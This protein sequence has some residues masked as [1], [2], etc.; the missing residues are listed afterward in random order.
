MTYT[1]IGTIDSSGG[2]IYRSNR[3]FASTNLLLLDNPVIKLDFTGAAAS[4][5]IITFTDSLSE[6]VAEWTIDD[7]LKVNY[8]EIGDVLRYA[9]QPVTLTADQFTD[10]G[11]AL[12]M[13]I[14]AYDSSDVALQTT[15][16]SYTAYRSS[17][18]TNIIASTGNNYVYWSLPSRFRMLFAS[19][20][21]NHAAYNIIAAYP[22]TGRLRYQ[23]YNGSS[24]MTNGSRVVTR[25]EA[26]NWL[27]SSQ[28]T[29]VVAIG[30]DTT[31][32][33]VEQPSCE[34]TLIALKW[35]SRIGGC[36][37][38]I[39]LDVVGGGYTNDNTVDY[40]TDLVQDQLKSGTT[41]ITGRFP[42]ATYKDYL[43]Y[44]D[45]IMGEHL[46]ASVHSFG[47]LEDVPVKVSG[48]W[49]YKQNDIKDMDFTITIK[50][51]DIDD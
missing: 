16:A 21:Y 35:W 1:Q 10:N 44:S 25:N 18:Y 39:L 28:I 6:V 27:A 43:Y 23:I 45:I 49:S 50:T 11:V 12:T 22:R 13:T 26:Y 41:Y 37:K 51:Y 32:V 8:V 7:T 40:W 42:N 14:V 9:V 5:V 29:H 31:T 19:N 46:T 24:L 4:Y 15:T 3:G 30:S 33:Q 34:S 48:S 17:A 2:T 47:G 36:W 20:Y 38:S